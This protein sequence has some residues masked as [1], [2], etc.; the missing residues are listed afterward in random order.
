[1]K[2][3]AIPQL[4]TPKTGVSEALGNLERLPQPPARAALDR[5]RQ[6]ALVLEADRSPVPFVFPT[7]VGGIQFEWKSSGRELDIEVLPEGTQLSFLTL[8]GGKVTSEGEILDN[9]ERRL[10]SLLTWVVSPEVASKPSLAV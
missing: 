2:E 4:R 6:I 5:A 10:R 9:F 3:K 1:M 8:L 7:D